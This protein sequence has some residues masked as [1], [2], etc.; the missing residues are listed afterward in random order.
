MNK[1]QGFI[2]GVLLLLSVSFYSCTK[3]PVEPEPVVDCNCD[4]YISHTK[5]NVSG[6]QFGEW[7]T[8]NDC[9]GL[10]LN[11]NWNTSWGDVEP[12]DGECK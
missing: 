9:T 5:W 1:E 11:G 7:I 2:V 4:R 8:I 10:Q 6:E 12:V 3:E